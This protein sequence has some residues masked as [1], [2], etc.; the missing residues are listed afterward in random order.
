MYT[1]KNNNMF[2]KRAGL[3]LSLYAF[4]LRMEDMLM[5]KAIEFR[6]LFIEIFK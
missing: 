1:I 2:F 3:P 6:A 5:R 4:F